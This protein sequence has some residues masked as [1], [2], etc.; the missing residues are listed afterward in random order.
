MLLDGEF[1]QQA[2]S[3]GESPNLFQLPTKTRFFFP[4]HKIFQNQHSHQA[5]FFKIYCSLKFIG[6]P[7]L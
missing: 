4:T 1:L 6:I 2:W 7:T 5:P 3:F